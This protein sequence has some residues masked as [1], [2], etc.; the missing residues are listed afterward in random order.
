MGTKSER[1]T[2]TVGGSKMPAYLARP[3]EDGQYPGVV[4]FMEIFGINAHIRSVADRVAAEGYVV[5]A[6]D[7]FHRTAPGI[8]LG[9]DAAG[10]GKGIELLGNV[11]ASELMAD[12]GAAID[13]L[14]QRRDVGGKGIGVMGFCAGGHAA[15]LTACEFP[16]RASACFYPGGVAHA[17][18]GNETPATLDRTSKIKGRILCMFGERDAYIPADDVAK[19]RAA[20]EAANVRHEL[21]VYPGV[22]HGFFCDARAD[23]DKASADDAWRRVKELFAAEL[24]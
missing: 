23:Y 7:V 24:A 6:P 20:L 8:E 18:P 2:V 19:I 17:A 16:V 10:L 9:Y 5:I 3:A 13:A 11:R 14:E 22:G 12:A 15:Y 4:V 1:L 21:V